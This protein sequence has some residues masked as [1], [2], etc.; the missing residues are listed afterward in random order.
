MGNYNYLEAIV[1]DV[2]EYIKYE[3]GLEKDD[4]LYRRESLEEKLYE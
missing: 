3:A 4:L 2:K 1:Y